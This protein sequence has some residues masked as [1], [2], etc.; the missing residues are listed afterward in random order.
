MR[1]SLTT[2]IILRG[3]KERKKNVGGC[4][5]EN[6]VEEWDGCYQQ[7]RSKKSMAESF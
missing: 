1:S 5:F 7:G 2:K 6:E 4:E 3:G